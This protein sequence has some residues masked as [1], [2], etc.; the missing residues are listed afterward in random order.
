MTYYSLN[1]LDKQIEKFVDFDGGVFFE[2][3][4]NNGIL[5]SNTAHFEL[6]RGWSGVLVEPIPERAEEAR[7]SRPNSKCFNA[8]LVPADYPD[9]VAH[10]TY[11]NMMTVTWGE[12]RV[13]DGQDHLDK[14]LPHIARR[15]ETTYEFTAPAR[16]ISSI[17]D[18]S[19]LD[20]VDFMSLDVEGY[21]VSALRGLDIDR[22]FIKFMCVEAKGPGSLDKIL[23]TLQG[24]YETVAKL[25]GYDYLIERKE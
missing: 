12:G 18:E 20:R 25:S 10:L 11:C 8:A 17:L 7:K 6:D 23:E 5:F 21:E 3:G 1:D 9:K 19:G 24:R 22:H 14:G 15:N 4:A 13:F 2:A 16:T